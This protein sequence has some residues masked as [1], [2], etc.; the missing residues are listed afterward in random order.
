MNY[1]ATFMLCCFISAMNLDC[2]L[3]STES[4]SNTFSTFFPQLIYARR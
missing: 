2:S 4:G 1:T 3:K